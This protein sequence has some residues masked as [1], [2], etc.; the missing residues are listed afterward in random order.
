MG[1]RRSFDVTKYDLG[2][3]NMKVCTINIRS[4]KLHN[5][6]PINH[7]TDGCGGKSAASV[8]VN[9]YIYT[10]ITDPVSVQVFKEPAQDPL[11]DEASRVVVAQPMS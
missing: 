6:E 3:G 7:A 9:T 11:N 8:T 10:T 4:A 2:Q 1:G 5:P